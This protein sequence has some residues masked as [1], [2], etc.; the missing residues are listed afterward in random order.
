[1]GPA[2]QPRPDV[3]RYLTGTPAVIGATALDA[4]LGPLLA[5]GMPALW[6]KA[7]GLVDLLARRAEELLTPLGAVLASPAD[8]A[9]RGGHLAIAHPDAWAACRL[10]DERQL[11]VADFRPPDVLRLA[12]VPSYTSYTE[13]W[14]AV[15]RIASVLADPMVHLPVPK[16]AIT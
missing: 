7:R 9:R 16:R 10:L 13:V 6:A 4:G 14:D 2:Y 1:M 11:V 3:G 5:A 12:P 8:P 15:E